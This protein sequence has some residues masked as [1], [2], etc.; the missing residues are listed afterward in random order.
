MKHILLVFILFVTSL[1]VASAQR[2]DCQNCGNV[3]AKYSTNTSNL[4]NLQIAVYPNPCTDYISVKDN[5][6]QI[7][8]IILFSMTGKKVRVFDDVDSNERYYLADI[9]NGMYLVQLVGKNNKVVRSQQ[10]NKR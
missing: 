1:T 8:Q 10:I 4:A 9:Q 3:G 6:N 5:D 2:E 7:G